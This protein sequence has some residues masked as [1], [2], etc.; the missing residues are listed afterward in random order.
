MVRSESRLVGSLMGFEG[1]LASAICVTRI[2]C[3]G[4]LLSANGSITQHDQAEPLFLSW[5]RKKCHSSGIFSI[6]VTAGSR[7]E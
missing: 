4:W 1:E 6:I 3:A 5:R 2:Q 7:A